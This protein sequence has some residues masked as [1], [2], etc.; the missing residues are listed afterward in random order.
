ML[1]Q[2]LQQM[3]SRLVPGK[4]TALVVISLVLGLGMGLIAPL[5]HR[6]LGGGNADVPVVDSRFVPVGKSYLP[7]LGKVYGTAWNEGAKALESGK[8]IPSS[9]KA[10]SQAWDSG[11]VQL[12]DRIVTPAFSKVVPESQDDAKLTDAD[13]KALARAWRG[14]AV[15]LGVSLK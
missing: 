2:W 12:F 8:D 15:G 3:L 6:W 14:F 1:K 10:V 5:V 11:R 4:S 7:E 9:L 13:R